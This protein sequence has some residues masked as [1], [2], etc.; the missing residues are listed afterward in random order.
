VGG[1]RTVQFV[2]NDGDGQ[3]SARVSRQVEVVPVNDPPI[4]LLP[5]GPQTI[6]EGAPP[7]LIDSTAIVIDPDSHDFDGGSLTVFLASGATAG[8]EIAI[9]HTGTGAG[10]VGVNALTNEVLYGGTV[11]GTYT[12]GDAGTPL[13]ISFNVNSA[14]PE[15]IQA[16]ARAITFQ[17]TS[18]NPP[19]NPRPIRFVATDGDG[20]T[21]ANVQITIT[22]TPI[23]DAPV[24]VPSRAGF[25]YTENDAPTA[26]DSGLT[27]IDPDSPQFGNG[28]LTANFLSGGAA[29][30]R[31]TIRNQGTLPGQVGVNGSFVT[32]NFGSGPVT[33]GSIT[34]SGI[35]LTNLQVTFNPSASLAAV[36]AVLRNVAYSNV[37]EAPS[38]VQ[39]VVRIVVSDG[40]GG[41]NNGFSAP[42]TWTVDVTSVNDAPTIG[43]V[44]SSVSYE[45]GF[46]AVVIAPLATV[47]DPDS[48]NFNTGWFQAAFTSGSLN[49]DVLAIRNQG[50]AAGRIGVSGSTV[51]YGGTP[52]GTF[53][54]GTD[55]NPLIVTF[56]AA[57]TP[58]AVQALVASITFNTPNGTGVTGIRTL[59]FSAI[60][61][62]PGGALSNTP[63]VSIDVTSDA[64][65]NDDFYQTNEDFVL[66]VSAIGVLAN[67]PNPAQLVV[68]TTQVTAPGLGDVVLGADGS[69]VYTPHPDVNGTDTFQYQW[70]DTITAATGIATVTIIINP[71]NDPP[72][73]Q[74]AAS[75]ITVNEDSGPFA[76]T[77]FLTTG[78]G[79]GPDEA[80]Q[81]VT[82]TVTNN[83]PAL[84][85]AQPAIDSA[86]RLTFTPAP[87]A[88][89]TATVT[90][91][92]QDS[93]GTF[94]NI[95]DQDTAQFTFTIVVNAVNDAPTF[96]II[97]NPPTVL[98]DAGPQTVVGFA[99]NFVPGPPNESHQT[100]TYL[101]TAIGTTGGLTFSD[102]PAIDA[103]GTLTYTAAPDSNG[104]ASFI[105]QVRDSG[106]TD[107][108]G[109]DLSGFR[110][111]T[112]TVTAV[113]DPPTLGD[114]TATVLW[115]SPPTAIPVLANDTSDPD[116]GGTVTVTA[117]SQPAN[118]TAAVQPG[119]IGVTYQPAPG[120]VGT[121]TFTYTARDANGNLATATVTVDVIRFQTQAVDIVALGSGPGGSSRVRIYNA[122]TGEYLT[123]FSAYSPHFQGGISVATGDVNG[124][125][126][127]DIILG[128]GPG[129]GPHVMVV[130][131]TR[132]GLLKGDDHI[133]DP[134][135]LLQSFFVYDFEFRGGVTVAAGDVNGDGKAD[136]IV[137]TGPGGAAHVRVISGAN[138]NQIGIDGLP[139]PSAMIANF[140]AYDENFRGGVKVAAGDV[141]GDGFVD[142]ITAAGSDGGSHVKAFD[143]RLLTLSGPMA[144]NILLASFYAF[145][146]NFRGGVNVAAGDF[147]GDGFAEFIVGAG[148]GGGSHVKVFSPFNLATPIASFMAFPSGVSGG[149]NI[150]YRARSGDASPLL[151]AATGT[152]VA[153]RL[154]AFAP[155]NFTAVANI[156]VFD[157][158][159]L[160]GVN[161]G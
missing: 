92:V 120:F 72:T 161:V 42:V 109:V 31:L 143:G 132:L 78:P 151:L 107:F 111:F 1:I 137:G 6:L 65:P 19:S 148:P 102:P 95:L 26:I 79:G 118:G 133:A 84:F 152:G 12:G 4:I 2:V 135:A 77:N 64:G 75:L 68:N 99:F 136:I 154:L 66:T 153:S 114:D 117:V 156:E 23:N 139:A 94:G 15:S 22:I 144:N 82:R 59:E 130:D 54:G 101:I 8:D 46:P 73:A 55:G 60:D 134:S 124:D 104:T 51:T 141:N 128:A 150:G 121:D 49:Q 21:S 45:A 103:S 138:I 67:D 100:P 27:L 158:G 38:T 149:V 9:Q 47:V 160:G 50:T 157:P 86:G 3:S 33:I 20:G 70:I 13:V 48:P 28:T 91:T 35:G 40:G 113:D 142:V 122:K 34:S 57:A 123:G 25:T 37:S 44:P 18:A 24:I 115:N 93:G 85:S 41:P 53:T 80:T 14:A 58:V 17:H 119:G 108:G 126:V 147:N 43:N 83:N 88:N 145:D 10:E 32:Y 127:T 89:G 155:P 69:F 71:V 112:I 39:R 87:N 61:F 146:P 105:V 125:G 106:G 52:I 63:V 62:S 36:Q 81:T 110:N 16:V 7:V 131:G 129:G 98:E 97:G 11:I 116:V 90:I 76:Q 96:Q 159:F 74:L 56:N 30:D 5:G 29:E 140:F